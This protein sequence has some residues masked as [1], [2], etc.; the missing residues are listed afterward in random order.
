[1][2]AKLPRVEPD[3][4]AVKTDE[5]EEELR[6]SLL[7]AEALNRGQALQ[8]YESLY[9]GH[10]GHMGRMGNGGHI[11][12]MMAQQ[13]GYAVMKQSVAAPLRVPRTREPYGS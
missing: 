13:G 3:A 8:L 11:W 9:V 2:V 1:M 12:V 6:R 10:M 7:H 4:E 5:S